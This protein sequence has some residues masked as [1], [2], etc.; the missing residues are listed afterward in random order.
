MSIRIE[1]YF[2]QMMNHSVN[3]D[4]IDLTLNVSTLIHSDIEIFEV[5]LSGLGDM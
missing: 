1:Q 3:Q 4:L 2:T 5:F